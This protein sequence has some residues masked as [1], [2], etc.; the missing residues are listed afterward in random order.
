MA[1]KRRLY[2]DGDDEDVAV[3]VLESVVICKNLA[4]RELNYDDMY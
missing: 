3:V 1:M 4:P 2:D